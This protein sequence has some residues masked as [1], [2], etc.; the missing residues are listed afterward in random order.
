MTRVKDGLYQYGGMPVLSGIPPFVGGD[1]NS[2][3]F[4]VDP[5]NGADG[6]SGQSPDDAFASL[7]RAHYMMTAG[8]NDVCFLIGNGSTTGTCRLSLANALAAQGPSETA[9]TTGTLTWSKAACHLI[10]IDA[11]TQINQ[12]ARISTAS[13]DTY[14]GFGSTADFV[15]I[16][17]SGCYF[18]NFAL[19]QGIAIGADGDITLDLTGDQNYFRNVHIGFPQ[20][21]TN[22][23]GTATRA[24]LFNGASENTFEAC[25]FGIDTVSRTAANATV[26]FA[27]GAS[28]RN[29]FRG[30]IF[31]S[32]GTSASI[33]HLLVTGTALDRWTLF[34]SCLFTD[35]AF[36][37]GTAMSTVASMTTNDPGGAFVMQNSSYA[38]AASGTKWGDT[39][40]LVQMRVDNVGGTTTGGL[41]L[42]PS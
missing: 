38:G 42:R 14:A 26:E 5:V 41:M 18:A 11:P 31:T 39:N 27:T 33:V 34:D 6:N 23:A 8:Q 13:G 21:S 35:N 20:G 30:C 19:I 15:K 36:A 17:A 24:A 25:T 2:K 7:Y 12:R 16:S 40:A 1:G 9:A 10:G 29:V 3:T 4:F 22:L 37:G 28:T 32:W